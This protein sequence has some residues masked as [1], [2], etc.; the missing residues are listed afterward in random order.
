[1][2]CRR[3]SRF[4]C[5]YSSASALAELAASDASAETNTTS[6]RRLARTGSTETC[7]GEVA[8]L[9]IS[10]RRRT[11]D[12]RQHAACEIA[13]GHDP[14]LR[15]EVRLR[16]LQVIRVVGGAHALHRERAFILEIDQQAHVGSIERRL[17]V[18]AESGHAEHDEERQ[19][20]DVAVAKEDTEPIAEMDLRGP[21]PHHWAARVA[22]EA[23]RIPSSASMP[24][25][26]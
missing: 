17:R 20:R 22:K 21:W 1:M 9:P 18:G 11:I 15:L 23:L 10:D 16:V 4:C 19:D 24:E 6:T 2:F 7:D 12:P 8:D 25:P 13:A 26:V 3:R 5:T 14:V